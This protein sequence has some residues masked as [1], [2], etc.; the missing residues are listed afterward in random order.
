MSVLLASIKPVI[1]SIASDTT[2]SVRGYLE[3]DTVSDLP[4]S[5]TDITGYTLVAGSVAHVI[6]DNDLY[7]MNSSGSWILQDRSPYSDVYTKSEVDSLLTPITDDISDLQDDIND[8]TDQ[9]AK[10]INEGCKNLVSIT[11]V[12][13]THNNVD[14][15]IEPDQSVTL[16]GIS[17]QYYTYKICGVQ[18][19]AAYSDHIPIKPGHYILT[20]CDNNASASTSRYILGLYASSDATRQSISIYGNYE[21]DITTDTARFDLAVYFA[22]G[23][24]FTNPIAHFYPMISEKWKWDLTQQFV[25]YSPTNAELAALIRQFHP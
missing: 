12:S 3:C 18:G 16:S 24:N 10:L 19:S 2:M 1:T 20:G 4:A 25:P 6:A 22:T 5:P 13:G 15:T 21:F 17:T 23:A 11:A 7:C 9:I 8:H 14:C